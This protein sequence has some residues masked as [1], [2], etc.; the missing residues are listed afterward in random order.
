[1]K[2]SRSSV[3]PLP[4]SVEEISARGWD[5]VDVVFVSGDGYV[6]HPSF[7]ASLLGRWLEAHGFRVAILAQPNW[8]SCD[9][10]RKFG[11]PRLCFAVTAG[12]MDSMV[13]HYTANR[14]VRNVD[15][16]TPGGKIGMRPDRASAVY[17]Q[18]AREAFPGVPILLGGVEASLRRLAHYDY[19][20]DKVRR[21]VLLDSKADLLSIGMG[22][23]SL[24]EMVQ[25]LD[26]GEKPS[27]MRD[28]PGTAYRLGASEFLTE[29]DEN[30][31]R[32]VDLAKLPENVVVLPSTEEVTADK[33]AFAQMTKMIYDELNP[34][35]GRPLFQQ[36][37][38]EAVVVNPPARPRTTEEMDEIYDLPFTRREHP[39]YGDAKIPALQ[40]VH[41]SIQAVRGCYGGCSFCSIGAHEGKIIQCRSK[42]SILIEAQRMADDLHFTGTITDIGGLT[43]NMYG[44]HCKNEAAQKVCKRSS[45]LFPAIC[46]NLET[47]HRDFID[48]LDAARRIEGVKNVFI[49]SG[50]RSDLA[51]AAPEYKEFLEKLITYHTGGHLSVAPEHV[52]AC[53]LKA[54]HK[55]EIDEFDRFVEDFDEM[56]EEIG[57]DYYTVPYF[58]ASHPGCRLADMVELAEYMHQ[59]GYKPQQMQD[60]YPTPFTIATCMYYTGLD[61]L[62]GE[63]VYCAHGDRER[64]MQ[65][66]LLQYFMPENYFTVR[67]ALEKVGRTDLIGPAAECLIP[68]NAPTKTSTVERASADRG[69]YRQRS[70]EEVAA[71]EQRAFQ[72]ALNEEGALGTDGPYK[73][74]PSEERRS[75]EERRSFGRSRDGSFDRPHRDRSFGGGRYS[76]NYDRF[77]SRSRF[78]TSEGE[79]GERAGR[80][81]DRFERADRAG[82]FSDRF[83]DRYAREKRNDEERGRRFDQGDRFDRGPR[84]DRGERFDRGDRFDRG[85][86]SERGEH[87][88]RGPRSGKPDRF[89]RVD[90]RDSWKTA[91]RGP[92]PGFQQTRDESGWNSYD[93][94][95][96]DF[97]NA[98]RPDRPDR[99]EDSGRPRSRKGSFPRNGGFG[100]GP[101]EHRSGGFGGG[102]REHRDGGFGG[103]REHR[104]GGFGEERRDG[105]FKGK[106]KNG[107][108]RKKKF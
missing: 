107:G 102:P 87:F 20:S 45:C 97:F 21:S 43:A 44:T 9:A 22:E 25:R 80:F 39:S 7:A 13:N 29:A 75:H 51:Q 55:P 74:K 65:R 62:T 108:F 84:P 2:N 46:P 49:A 3:T 77:E 61:P 82:R 10:W 52:S 35:S 42:G 72:R 27:E 94:E 101:R 14:K 90:Y 41:D 58:I 57:K 76:E 105:G 81:S 85:P 54:M 69:G 91:R 40:T 88:D 26:A 6:D 93:D 17:C 70:R 92:R 5:Q 48:L 4:M 100:G 95:N 28:I 89:G 19:W 60:F 12:N 8:K 24:L 16:Y 99:R 50:I 30:G 59:Y 31:N 23:A 73:P 47:S 18:R 96:Q 34:F 64:K 66:A 98:E 56:T 103:P 53:V 15:A 67:E 78:S 71:K 106:R 83:A 33:K 32:T 79:G 37:G 68:A 86:R 11:K 38:T 36:C 104:N 63:E 1:M